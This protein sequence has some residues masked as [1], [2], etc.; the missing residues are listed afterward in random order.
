[1]NGERS[2]GAVFSDLLGELTALFRT[3]IR[4][5]R[6]EF[7]EKLGKMGTG[8][9][10]T[11]AGGLVLFA[12][13]LF[14]L[15]AAVGG[16]VAAGLLLWQAALIVAVATLVVGAIVLWLGLSRLNAKQLAPNKTV[17]QLQRDAAVAR[18]QVQTS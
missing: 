2:L 13:F 3:E 9:A 14:L 4:L 1:M 16:L 10:M 12:G 6:T 17:H 8:I 5:A 18:Y 11:A 15:A 7:S